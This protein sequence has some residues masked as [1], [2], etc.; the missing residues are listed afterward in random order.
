M[1][2]QVG[3]NTIDQSCLSGRVIQ[4]TGLHQL[5]EQH[6]KEIGQVVADLWRANDKGICTPLGPTPPIV[7]QGCLSAPNLCCAV[8]C[9]VTLIPADIVVVGQSK[10][11][12]GMVMIIGMCWTLHALPK[13]QW[14]TAICWHP[15]STPLKL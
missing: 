15:E 13:V 5:L 9:S 10:C 12:A 6:D 2:Q 14:Q 3:P 11:T 4:C 7:K 1:H 8:M